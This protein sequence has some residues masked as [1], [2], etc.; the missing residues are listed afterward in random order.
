[1]RNLDYLEGTRADCYEEGYEDGYRAGLNDA[2]IDEVDNIPLVAG[3][4]SIEYQER[5]KGSI[6]DMALE[7]HGM[8]T[9]ASD[10]NEEDV[11]NYVFCI[12]EVLNT[13]KPAIHHKEFDNYVKKLLEAAIDEYRVSNATIKRQVSNLR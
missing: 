2:S 1:M 13:W 12:E 5:C 11:S 10:W 3:Y 7:L 6:L 4:R 9:G 8:I